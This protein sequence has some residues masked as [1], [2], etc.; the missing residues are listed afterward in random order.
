MRCGARDAH[1]RAFVDCCVAEIEAQEYGNQIRLVVSMGDLPVAVCSE[2][3]KRMGSMI[4]K[5]KTVIEGIH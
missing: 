1:H 5:T 2:L 3:A 4:G